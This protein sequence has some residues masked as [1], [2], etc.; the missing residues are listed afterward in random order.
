MLTANGQITAHAQLAVEMVLNVVTEPAPT[1][2]HNTEENL[3]MVQPNK[4]KGVTTKIAQV[5]FFS[6][7]LFVDVRPLSVS[8]LRAIT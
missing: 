3:A 1:Q 5:K 6:D 2:P 8:G 7:C 4:L